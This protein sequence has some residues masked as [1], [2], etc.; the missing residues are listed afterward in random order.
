MIVLISN[1]IELWLKYIWE[2]FV[3]VNDLKTEYQL[4]TYKEYESSNL[5]QKNIF[6]IEYASEQQYPES[7]FILKK[8]KFKTDQYIWI[9]DDL[10]I[11]S[12]TVVE[13]NGIMHYDIFYNAFIHLSRLEEWVAE[14][15]GTF[16]RRC[17]TLLHGAHF[18]R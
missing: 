6:L 13:K 14:S 18:S 16:I 15:N 4:Y 3:Q 11:Y 1:Y 2:Q 9:L 5:P 8:N 7:L 17:N 10:P 12:D